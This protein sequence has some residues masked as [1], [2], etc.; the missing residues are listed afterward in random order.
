[1]LKLFLNIEICVNMLITYQLLS[2]TFKDVA[3]AKTIV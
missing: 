1:M 2:L 3:L